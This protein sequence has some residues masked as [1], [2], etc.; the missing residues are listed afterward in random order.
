MSS[1]N[2]TSLAKNQS[3]ILT[4]TNENR[5]RNIFKACL[6]SS[7]LALMLSSG[8]ASGSSPAKNINV[9]NDVPALHVGGPAKP[10]GLAGKNAVIR[11]FDNDTLTIT[12]G[13][14][15]NI[16]TDG[17]VNIGEIINAGGLFTINNVVNIAA[18]D[19]AMSILVN[20]AGSSLNELRP[21]DMNVAG[22]VTVADGGRA[23]IK[24]VTGPNNVTINGVGSRLTMHDAEQDLIANNG[25][26]LAVNNVS[27]NVTLDNAAEVNQTGFIT[28]DLNVGGNAIFKGAAATDVGGTVVINTTN[29]GMNTLH[30]STGDVNVTKGNVTINEAR[31]ALTVT[32]GADA[33]RAKV[34]TVVG[35]TTIGDD[36]SLVNVIDEG[37]LAGVEGG[38]P[39]K[40]TLNFEGRGT[41]TGTIGNVSSLLAVNF[42]GP[43]EV[44]LDSI[45]KASTFNIKNTAAIVKSNGLMTGNVF[46]EDAGILNVNQGLVGNIDFVN[47]AGIANLAD[48]K[49]ITGNIDA[50]GNPNG[51]L[52]FAG[53]GTVTGTIGAANKL[54][55]VNFSGPGNVELRGESKAKAFNINSG[56]ANVIAAEAIEGEVIFTVAGGAMTTA[57]EKIVTGNID[58]K[59]DGTFNLASGG[60]ITGAVDNNAKVPAVNPADPAVP[61]AAGTLNV[62]AWDNLVV[63][64]NGTEIDGAIGAT[65]ELIAVNFKGDGLITLNS[66]AN[67]ETFTVGDLVV[68]AGSGPTSVVAKGLVKGNVVFETRSANILTVYENIEKLPGAAAANTID[69]GAGLNLQTLAFAGP[70]ADFLNFEGKI[71]NGG[72]GVINVETML[73]VTDESIGTMKTINIGTVAT[74]NI[75]RIDATNNDFEILGGEINFKHENS[76]LHFYSNADNKNITI[77]DNLSGLAGVGVN[78]GIVRLH[79]NGTHSLNIKSNAAIKN[80]G[81]LANKLNE[82]SVQGKVNNLGD[83]AGKHINL[84]NILALNIINGAEFTD[85]TATSAG[86]KAVHIGTGYDG[87]AA[88]PAMWKL[89]ARDRDFDLD[90]NDIVF[91]H[92]EANLVLQNTGA[93]KTPRIVTLKGTLNPVIDDKGI[94]TLHASGANGAAFSTLKLTNTADET[95][96]VDNT[97]RLKQL[98]IK[99]DSL[100]NNISVGTKVFAKNITLDGSANITFEKEIDSGLDSLL[101]FNA[102]MTAT[103]NH[104]TI[105]KTINFSNH[106]ATLKVADGEKFNY[107]IRKYSCCNRN[108]RISWHKYSYRNSSSSYSWYCYDKGW[109]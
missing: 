74:P 77:F 55:A 19:L 66:T 40:G 28:G 106:A 14:L 86:I 59:V 53:A 15:R 61:T 6:T 17:N 48:G 30:N 60:K 11:F 21:A 45:A 54:A 85:Y 70:R 65:K 87:I 64:A 35:L 78:G 58:F 102:T 7:A 57:N 105:V 16:T 84:S 92:A 93:S 63:H 22:A 80:L 97:S 62:I 25:I 13:F 104:D 81:T 24:D 29:L 101:Q 41:V 103:L 96:G 91:D 31:S 26:V 8:S 1:N 50:S 37:Q 79:A 44:V 5:L 94:V 76:Q 36:N 100:G 98:I 52:N 67:A 4:K 43:G 20:G 51:T 10:A 47:N 33:S 32:G 38:G 18:G 99:G 69:F 109:G 23:N 83:D 39:G 3:S 42:S 2:I 108:C 56:A 12:G 49:T 46:F 71:V 73:S 75:F 95:L 27:R 82:L 90:G 9:I 89:D 34:K 72:K 68:A 88:G 107:Y